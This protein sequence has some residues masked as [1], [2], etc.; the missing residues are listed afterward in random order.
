MQLTVASGTGNG[1]GVV[2][3]VTGL[4]QAYLATNGPDHAS[5]IPTQHFGGAAFRADVL[6]NLGVH[7]VDG[8]GLDVHQQ[9]PWAGDGFW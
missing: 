3:L 9:V 6:A 8:D 4:E 7:R 1:A 5:H 2:D